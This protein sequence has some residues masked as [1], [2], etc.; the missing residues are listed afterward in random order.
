MEYSRFIGRTLGPYK[1][2]VPLGK[3][4][5][6]SVYRAYQASVDRYVAIKVMMPEIAN[7]PSFVERFQ[8][9]ARIIARLEHPHILPVI[10]FGEA[11]GVYYIV[12][13]YMDGG[14]LDDRLR[15]RRLTP[16]EISHYLDQ[17][18]SALD[19]AHQ[20]GVIHRDLK[21]NNVLLD[22]ANNCYLTDFG[23]ARIEGAERKLTAT[24]SVMGTPAYMSPEQAMGRL[25][26]GRSDLYALGI[27]LYEM[28]TG[29]LPFTADSTAALIFQHVYEAPPLVRQIDPS[30]PEAVDALFSR[31]LAK[32]PD[33]RHST[34][35]ELAQDFAEIFGIRG[36]PSRVVPAAPEDKTVIGEADAL[37]VPTAPQQART[38][39]PPAASQRE[40]TVVVGSPSPSGKAAALEKP[41]RSA[42]I[43]LIGLLAVALI[44]LI[45]GGL[46]FLNSQ[47]QS[48]TQTAQ[49]AQ[50]ATDAAIALAATNAQAT[51]IA[52]SATPTSTPT[53]TLTA[54][55]TFTATATFTNTPDA[56]ETL[57]AA[58]LATADALETVQA[59]Q[60]Q[61]ALEAAQS[62][63]ALSAT[64]T[65]QAA[66]NATATFVQ[67]RLQ[68]AEAFALALTAT[69]EAFK[70]ATANAALTQTAIALLPTATP[71]R[72]ARPTLT[73]TPTGRPTREPVFNPFATLT[74]AVALMKTAM[75]P[76]AVAELPDRIPEL[77]YGDLTA[78]LD[79]LRAR[80]IISP[81][82]ALI[83]V[84]VVNAPPLMRGNPDEEDVFYLQPFSRAFFYDFLLSVDVSLGAPEE[85]RDKTWCGIY[86]AATNE[87]YGRTDL[88]DADMGIFYYRQ[89]QDYRLMTRV[90]ETWAETALARGL[91]RAIR[92]AD[93][94]RNRLTLVM[95]DGLLSVYIN[96]ALVAQ[97]KEPRFARGGSI[98]YF[99][100][101]GSKGLGHS[102]NFQS[103]QLW[104]LN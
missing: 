40:P 25:V 69:S 22:R 49:A 8:R 61:R 17:I 78:A 96:G 19:Y 52:L 67:E 80:G 39:K 95:V 6:A 14:S 74:A 79:I 28:L 47:N 90:K 20:K 54:T 53:A 60:T 65:L 34:A 24:G 63:T 68:T 44:A 13:R 42:P 91:S 72:T 38:P 58:R 104:R 48:A 5:M 37:S 103:V 99:M 2:E 77:T 66:L 27:M 18:A 29:K 101:R 89:A 59:L 84:P 87:Q 4:G 36:T 23:I 98:G 1:L 100:I 97:A 32:L 85:A 10:D 70:A 73:R 21:P 46:F 16:Y 88:L 86:F 31:A 62:A 43:A 11:D 75:A 12:M 9:E 102:C 94:A 81:D 50:N 35:E 76:T 82:A 33:A 92:T 7:D 30:L 93:G 45:G 55:P 71:T 57:I 3:G 51:L 41:R 15:Q 64:Q 56:T 83:A 26:D